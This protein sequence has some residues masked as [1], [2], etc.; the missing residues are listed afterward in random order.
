MEAM[1]VWPRCNY[2]HIGLSQLD[3]LGLLL[4]NAVLRGRKIKGGK[5]EEKTEA[6][7]SR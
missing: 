1:L 6:E 4:T 2:L 7:N 3:K 5:K